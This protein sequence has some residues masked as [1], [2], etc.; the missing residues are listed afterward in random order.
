MLASLVISRRTGDYQRADAGTGLPC[1]V[2]LQHEDARQGALERFARMSVVLAG[3][4]ELR[5][6]ANALAAGGDGATQNKLNWTSTSE[7]HCPSVRPLAYWFAAVSNSTMTAPP[8][9]D[10]ALVIAMVNASATCEL[11]ASLVCLA[12]GSMT[13]ATECSPCGNQV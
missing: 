6:D 7:D 8:M 12:Q 2:I 11:S 13:I 1:D 4:G 5:V 10:R 3:T 9:R